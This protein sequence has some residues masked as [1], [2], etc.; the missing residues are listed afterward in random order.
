[1]IY[2]A[3]VQILKATYKEIQTNEYIIV[4]KNNEAEKIEHD[5]KK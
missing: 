2:I 1:M 5:Q 4:K 3:G